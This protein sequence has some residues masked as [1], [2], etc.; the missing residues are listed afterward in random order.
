[1]RDATDAIAYAK[2]REQA[3]LH[4]LAVIWN[5]ILAR[6]ADRTGKP[7]VARD[8]SLTAAAH[9]LAVVELSQT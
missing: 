3:K 1:M 5:S 8:A 6:E 4:V 2:R 7:A 9:A